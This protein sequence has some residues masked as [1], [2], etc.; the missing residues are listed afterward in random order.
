MT[1]IPLHFLKRFFN[2]FDKSHLANGSSHLANGFYCN[3]QQ[4]IFCTRL[5]TVGCIGG[6]KGGVRDARP[7]P[8]VQ[9]LQFHA[10]LGEIWQ[11][12]ALWRVHA[13][14]IRH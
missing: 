11:N 12:L 7:P 3:S 10:V 1:E 9:I 8:G 6:Y 14:W 13:P 5:N 4:V 2:V